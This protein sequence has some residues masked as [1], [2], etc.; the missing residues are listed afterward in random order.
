[1]NTTRPNG[2]AS[3]KRPK[4]QRKTGK[5]IGGYSPNKLALRM[6]KRKQIPI[7]GVTN[8]EVARW[9][10]HLTDGTEGEVSGTY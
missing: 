10:F 3:K 2:K 6:V 1:M 9:F 5:T 7:V 8:A 4:V